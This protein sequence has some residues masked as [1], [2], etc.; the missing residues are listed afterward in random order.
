MT[1]YLKIILKLKVWLY[2]YNQTSFY[3]GVSDTHAWD[4]CSKMK[5]NGTCQDEFIILTRILT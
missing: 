1:I 4:K 2:I 5:P 3:P